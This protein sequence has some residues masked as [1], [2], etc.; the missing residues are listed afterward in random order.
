MAAKS[1]L[2]YRLILFLIIAVAVT[3]ISPTFKK[4]QFASGVDEGY[5]FKYA[6]FISAKGLSGFSELFKGY[7]G[8][9]EHW[10]FPSPLRAGYIILSAVW[11]KIFGQSFINL[12]Y[13]SLFCYVLFLGVN[14]YFSKKYLGGQLA[15]LFVLLLAFS[16]L[17]LAMSRRALAEAAV[18][19]FSSLSIWF[20][21]DFLRERK[22]RTFIFF[23]A[24]MSVN[25]LI[26]ESS[27]LLVF[28]FLI[29]WLIDKFIYQGKADFKECASILI[30]PL[31]AAGLAFWLL[32]CLPYLFSAIKIILNSPGTN[33]YAIQFGSG[34]WYRYLIDYM[35]LSPWAVILALGFILRLLLGKADNEMHAYFAAF[36]LAA[37]ILLNIFTKNVRYAIVLDMPMRLF[38]LLMLERI[39]R[40]IF[41]QQAIKLLS[42]LVV[43]LA[44]SDYF[45]FYEIFVQGGVYDPASFLLLKAKHIIPFN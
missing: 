38:S 22:H 42:V 26:K 19:L 13:F 37:F 8:N 40:R 18:N 45:N 31:F 20:F 10:L 11:L 16:P 7:L 1:T 29:L 17:Q 35:L 12:A 28:T 33:A 36:F 5:Y 3:L 15:L 24:A 44:F 9:Q 2:Q 21:W 43:A 32:R 23:I 6:A 34:P 14:Y 4:I 39:T 27:A 25:I 41:P 30:F